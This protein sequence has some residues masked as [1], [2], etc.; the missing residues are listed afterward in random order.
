MD[1]YLLKARATSS[2]E[3]DLS[4]G[5][6]MEP[7]ESLVRE[8]GSEALHFLQHMRDSLCV[9]TDLCGLLGPVRL[10]E[11]SGRGW[12]LRILRRMWEQMP[13]FNTG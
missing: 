1:T 2:P 6:R 10:P 5:S 3:A 9:L 4:L 7:P 13:V 8:S 11:D 12:T